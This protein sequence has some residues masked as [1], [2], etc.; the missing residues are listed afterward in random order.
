MSD[1][2]RFGSISSPNQ[3]TVRESIAFLKTNALDDFND[4]DKDEENED[5]L[6]VYDDH[7]DDNDEEENEESLPIQD[8]A[9]EVS[10]LQS[11]DDA[12]GTRMMSGSA[13]VDNVK[14]CATAEE[15]ADDEEE[16]EPTLPIHDDA[17]EVTTLPSTKK[18]PDQG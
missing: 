4:M 7:E 8:E 2:M 1:K 3:W 15:D 5:S 6:P 11:T 12:A 18:A 16:N 9:E 14:N 13:S 10:T 17:Q